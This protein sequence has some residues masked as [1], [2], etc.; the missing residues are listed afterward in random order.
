MALR[1]GASV[2]RK[3]PEAAN[4]VRWPGGWPEKVRPFCVSPRDCAM[5]DGRL[6]PGC[7]KHAESWVDGFN[8]NRPASL[9]ASFRVM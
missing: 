6:P 5:S 8:G 9:V 1:S 4:T 2:Q 3:A 7:R